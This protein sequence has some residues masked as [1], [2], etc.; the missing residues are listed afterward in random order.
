MFCLQTLE[1]YVNNAYW[2]HGA[3]GISAASAAYFGKTPAQLDVGEASL[4]AALLPCP[5]ELSPY[6]N[7]SG[8][9]R[10]RKTALAQMAGHGYLTDKEAREWADAPLPAKGASR[11]QK[12][13]PLRL[14]CLCFLCINN[15]VFIQSATLEIGN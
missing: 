15:M 11:H 1:A 4:L 7:P 12:S 10:A 2:G 9:L 14:S 5:D 6:A 13:C 8:A 3:F